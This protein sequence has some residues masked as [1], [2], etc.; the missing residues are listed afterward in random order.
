MASFCAFLCS[1]AS[2]N[3][4]ILDDGA[5][6]ITRK[7]RLVNNAGVASFMYV[8]TSRIV[9]H[10][11]TSGLDYSNFLCDRKSLQRESA[12]GTTRFIK[13]TITN[14]SNKLMEAA[15]IEGVGFTL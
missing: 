5:K 14:K 3:T 15:V 7:G 12:D 11:N 13:T 9:F 4:R 6:T 2:N 8:L 1:A 10:K